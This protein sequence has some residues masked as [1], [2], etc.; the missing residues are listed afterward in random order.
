MLPP[1]RGLL[2]CISLMHY[3]GPVRREPML[4]Q[5]VAGLLHFKDGE[6]EA[7][8][9]QDRHICPDAAGMS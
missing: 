4:L 1:L 9:N 7:P 2:L 3:P 5:D 6:K 8:L